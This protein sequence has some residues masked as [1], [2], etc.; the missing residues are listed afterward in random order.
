MLNK[1]LAEKYGALGEG[2]IQ[3]IN[4][5]SL[6]NCNILSPINEEKGCQL[7]ITAPA[8]WILPIADKDYSSKKKTNKIYRQRFIDKE[9]Y[10]WLLLKKVTKYES[11]E[12]HF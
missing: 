2:H 5:T 7:K 9:V 12:Y 6:K 10:I 8:L 11:M 3:V 4:L 1:T